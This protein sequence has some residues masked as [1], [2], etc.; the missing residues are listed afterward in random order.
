MRPWEQKKLEKDHSEE[1][2]KHMEERGWLVEKVHGSMY[3]QG[4]PD[5]YCF[6]PRFGQRWLEMKIPK[7]GLL[8]TTQVRKFR[9]WQAFG[10][11]VVVATTVKDYPS[12]LE[13][14]ANWWRWMPGAP[15]EWKK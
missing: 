8:E 2:R 1:L 10:I 5:F 4:W 7:D 11:V 12:V 9:K 6:H 3:M 13:N 15:K 14:K